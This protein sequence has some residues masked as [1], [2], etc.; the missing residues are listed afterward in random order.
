[1]TGIK[2]LVGSSFSLSRH[3]NKFTSFLRSTWSLRSLDYGQHVAQFTLF[4]SAFKTHESEENY[5]NSTYALVFNMELQWSEMTGFF[6]YN[7]FYVKIYVP[8]SN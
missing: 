6:N 7:F 4:G 2:L 8:T 3:K 1:M 5:A